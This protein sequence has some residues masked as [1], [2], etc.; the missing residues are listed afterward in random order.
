MFFNIS[1]IFHFHHTQQ[2]INTIW[3]LLLSPHHHLSSIS[4]QPNNTTWTYSPQHHQDTKKT[5]QFFTLSSIVSMA[6]SPFSYNQ[7]RPISPLTPHFLV[8][9]MILISVGCHFCLFRVIFIIV[10]CKHPQCWKL[11]QA[12]MFHWRLFW[13]VLIFGESKTNF[14]KVFK[15]YNIRILI[16]FFWLW[17]MSF[18]KSQSKL[19]NEYLLPHTFFCWI[20]Q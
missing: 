2:T 18:F 12:R 20:V 5:F 4:Q 13:K 6:S 16:S 3:C 8:I 10:T 9:P 19:Q 7:P 17:M 15:N 11:W 14:Y 1:S